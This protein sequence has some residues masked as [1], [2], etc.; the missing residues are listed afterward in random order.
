VADA[1]GAGEHHVV[2]LAAA[3]AVIT[4]AFAWGA[5][6]RRQTADQVPKG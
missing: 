2:G 6:R 3:A 5:T 1:L 4:L